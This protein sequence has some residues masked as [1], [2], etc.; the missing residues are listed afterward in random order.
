MMARRH[1]RRAHRQRLRDLRGA[2]PAQS[3]YHRIGRF[4]SDFP[5]RACLPQK[6][7]RE[8]GG[9]QNDPSHLCNLVCADDF[10][11]RPTECD[12]WKKCYLQTSGKMKV[13]L[14]QGKLCECRFTPLL[15][16]PLNKTP[17]YTY[18]P[19]SVWTLLFL[20]AT[21]FFFVTNPDRS[22]PLG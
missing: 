13:W 6:K 15:P 14:K 5:S 21:Q 7:Q 10:K 8:F 18:P 4:A 22:I 11:V 17:T 20:L 3:W 2:Q 19:A 12:L 1:H 16:L 9:N